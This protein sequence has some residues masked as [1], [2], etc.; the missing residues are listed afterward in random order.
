MLSSASALLPELNCLSVSCDAL[1][2]AASP[3]RRLGW[4]NSLAFPEKENA[5]IELP[6]HFLDK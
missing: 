5:R 4:V 3:D 1:A 6:V 2:V